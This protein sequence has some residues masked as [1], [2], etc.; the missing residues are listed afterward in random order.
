MHSDIEE[1]EIHDDDEDD[2]VECLE[3][4]SERNN[5]E[6]ANIGISK[7]KRLFNTAEERQPRCSAGC[8]KHPKIKGKRL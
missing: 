1:I 4:C 6:K 8:P 5:K 3:P 7:L 2:Y